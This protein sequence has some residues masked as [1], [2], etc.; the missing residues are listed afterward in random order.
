MK[1]V[2]HRAFLFSFKYILTRLTSFIFVKCNDQARKEKLIDELT[3]EQ[4]IDET[5]NEGIFFL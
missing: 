1:F 2:F 5:T 4:N 3:N